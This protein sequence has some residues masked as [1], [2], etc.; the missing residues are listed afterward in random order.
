MLAVFWPCSAHFM[1]YV[2]EFFLP[3]TIRFLSRRFLFYPPPPYHF[4]SPCPLSSLVLVH[5]MFFL[6]RG[7]LTAMPHCTCAAGFSVG[8]EDRR[9]RCGAT[10]NRKSMHGA[11]FGK[12]WRGYELACDATY[13]A[14]A[15]YVASFYFLKS[16]PYC[17]FLP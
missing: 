10:S 1:T 8:A 13:T 15:Y 9:E 12:T 16:D 4:P 6:L 2:S 7:G 14:F 11:G 17:C 3:P 5:Q